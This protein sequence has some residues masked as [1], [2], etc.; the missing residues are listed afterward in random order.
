[1]QIFK[2][3]DLFIAMIGYQPKVSVDNS[4]GKFWTVYN[5]LLDTMFSTITSKLFWIS[6]HCTYWLK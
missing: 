6:L 2:E 4:N 3:F 1:L 5:N